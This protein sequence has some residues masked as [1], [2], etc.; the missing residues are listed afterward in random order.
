MVNE[1]MYKINAEF[2]C[3]VLSKYAFECGPLAPISAVLAQP[4][5][6]Y[7]T[8]PLYPHHVDQ[9]NVFTKI[10]KLTTYIFYINFHMYV[11]LL[12]FLTVGGRIK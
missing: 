5:N 6:Y 7:T 2:Q 9:Y 4:Q 10:L 1:W 11:N 3:T 8:K 12:V